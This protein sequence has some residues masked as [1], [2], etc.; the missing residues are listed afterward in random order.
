[1]ATLTGVIE[2][3]RFFV[4]MLFIVMMFLSVSCGTSRPA[5]RFKVLVPEKVVVYKEPS[6]RSESFKFSDIYIYTFEKYVTDKDIGGFK[7]RWKMLKGNNESIF[8]KVRLNSGQEGYINYIDFAKVPRRYVVNM[9]SAEYKGTGYFFTSYDRVWQV[10]VASLNKEGFVILHMQ[11]GNG[12][13][14]TATKELSDTLRK[15]VVV[16]LSHEAGFI[17]VNIKIT[18]E[19]RRLSGT[20]LTYGSWSSSSSRGWTEERIMKNMIRSLGRHNWMPIGGKIDSSG[21]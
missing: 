13:L 9:N 10:A 14:S 21:E 20:P 15:R 12:Y 4:A 8:Y 7:S 1:M 2:M 11:K 17:K 5:R 3:K 6:R 18:G 16:R 19:S